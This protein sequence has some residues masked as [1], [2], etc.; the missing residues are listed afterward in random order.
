M[1]LVEWCGAVEWLVMDVVLLAV[2]SISLP[3]WLRKLLYRRCGNGERAAAT[4]VAR[5]VVDGVVGG[6]AGASAV[7]FQ[8]FARTHMVCSLL[9]HLFDSSGFFSSKM[10]D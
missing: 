10:I 4:E 9:Y 5:A 8:I 7:A 2:G 1:F 3:S 6:K